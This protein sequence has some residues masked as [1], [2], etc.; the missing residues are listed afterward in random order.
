ML[1]DEIIVMFIND[2]E[3]HT[4]TK[5]GLAA[6]SSCFSRR[7][8]GHSPRHR[9]ES[10][11]YRRA[12]RK[13]SSL[14]QPLSQCYAK[15]GGEPEQVDNSRRQFGFSGGLCLALADWSVELRIL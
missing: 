10:A 13:A 5:S 1:E 9:A 2:M 14:T 4:E 12:L 8:T 6:W 15:G 11:I 7:S 3:H